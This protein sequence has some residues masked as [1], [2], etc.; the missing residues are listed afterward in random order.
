[1]YQIF[2]VKRAAGER[3]RE[4]TSALHCDLETTKSYFAKPADPTYSSASQ[5]LGSSIILDGYWQ[6][7]SGEH[8]EHAVVAVVD[9]DRDNYYI[10]FADT[11]PRYRQ[12]RA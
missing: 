6:K 10:A 12:W 11:N 3:K 1:V 7:S 8:D 5:S 4:A 9:A 2:F